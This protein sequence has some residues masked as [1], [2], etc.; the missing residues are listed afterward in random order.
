MPVFK[1]GRGLAPAWC[2]LECFDIVSL[3]PGQTHAYGR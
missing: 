1:S 3:S 2:E